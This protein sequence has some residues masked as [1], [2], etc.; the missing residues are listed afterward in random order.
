MSTLTINNFFKKFEKSGSFLHGVFGE[1]HYH[2]QVVWKF[3]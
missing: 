2:V 3:I 1:V